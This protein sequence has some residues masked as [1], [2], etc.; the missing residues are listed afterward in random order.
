VHQDATTSTA[1]E[2][3]AA[4]PSGQETK[5]QSKQLFTVVPVKFF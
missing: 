4:N 2:Q 1:A 3:Y 5:P